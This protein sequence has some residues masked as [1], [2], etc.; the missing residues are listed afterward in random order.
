MILVSA[1]STRLRKW[2]VLLVCMRQLGCGQKPIGNQSD[3]CMVSETNPKREGQV[4]IKPP[5]LAM[6]QAGVNCTLKTDR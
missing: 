2:G 4:L 6:L 3:V 1:L 5:A